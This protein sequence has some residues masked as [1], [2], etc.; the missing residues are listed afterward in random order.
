MC[1]EPVLCWL[2]ICAGFKF[3]YIS[4]GVVAFLG[5]GVG[6]KRLAARSI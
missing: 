4:Y 2:F 5:N 3:F 6:V 1:A